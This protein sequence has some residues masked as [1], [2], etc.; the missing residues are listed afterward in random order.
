MTPQLRMIL[1]L[2]LLVAIG[3]LVSMTL[4]HDLL[5]LWIYMTATV[6]LAKYL[7]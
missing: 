6:L 1:L 3:F 4:S 7:G 2:F 5:M